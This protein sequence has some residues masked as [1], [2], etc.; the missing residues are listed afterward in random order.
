MSMQR[1]RGGM[2][3]RAQAGIITVGD[4]CPRRCPKA[5]QQRSR[6]QSESCGQLSGTGAWVGMDDSVQ[7]AKTASCHCH[8]HVRA[9]GVVRQ[10]RRPWLRAG[11]PAALNK[12]LAGFVTGRSAVVP[13]SAA[14]PSTLARFNTGPRILAR[15][16]WDRPRSSAPPPASQ[17]RHFIRLPGGTEFRVWEGYLHPPP[18][19]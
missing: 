19:Q 18:P 3:G 15:V 16:G 1:P 7:P 8:G 5:H 14:N 9:T 6:V 13:R 4:G 10:R 2:G 12:G 17:A 11:W